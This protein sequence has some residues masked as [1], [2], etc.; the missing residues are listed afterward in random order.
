VTL[1]IGERT[2]REQAC[3]SCGRAYAHVTGFVYA[4]GDAH[5]VYFAAC[6]G[7]PDH[8][9]WLD[10][11]VGTWGGDEAGDHVTFSCR[12]RGDGATAVDAPVAVE[13]K[14]RFMGRRLTRDEALADSRVD[15][16][17]R[18]VDLVALEDSAVAAHLARA[19]GPGAHQG[20]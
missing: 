19:G 3:S 18:V 9:A 16:F 2:V 7:H 17:W 8:E 11:V 1:S 14:G 10:V 15:A 13:G 6:H 4:E 20:A 5:A 12:L